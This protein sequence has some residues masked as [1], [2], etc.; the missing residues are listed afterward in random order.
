MNEYITNN[1]DELYH[2]GVL[3]MKW[4]VRRAVSKASRNERLRKKALNYD[5]KSDKANRKSEKIHSDKDLGRANKAA[6][7]AAN[8]SIKSEKL[9]KKALKETG[10]YA[11]T[12]LEKKAAK[13]D[14]KSATQRMK[15]NQLS[16]TTG[17]GVRAMKYSIKSDKMA[18]KATKVRMKMANNEAYIAKMK[19]K[20]NSL[21]E[22]DIQKGQR[23]VEELLGKA[24]ND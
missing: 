2:Y 17:Y 11:R 3:G 18:R 13:A 5:I 6:K 8:Y 12:K 1:P 15:A 9:Q 4:G 23:Y 14:Y 19:Q 21:P 20:V 24:K 10:D 16:K 7:K 22:Q